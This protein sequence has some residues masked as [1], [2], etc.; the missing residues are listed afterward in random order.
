[1][2]IFEKI[3]AAREFSSVRCG[4]I[5]GKNLTL[6]D[7]LDAFDLCRNVGIYRAMDRT[8]A[9]DLMKGLLHRDLAYNA[10]TMPL[11]RA[12]ELTEMFFSAAPIDGQIFSNRISRPGAKVIQSNAATDTM[13]DAGILIVG[14]TTCL[15]FWVEEED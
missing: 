2:D 14:E 13:F 7:T 1:M 4:K 8:E 6:A 5:E 9:M 3:I 12:R 11:E 10:E 15:C